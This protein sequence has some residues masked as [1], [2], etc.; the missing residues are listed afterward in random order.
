MEQGTSFT[1]DELLHISADTENRLEVFIKSKRLNMR[2]LA[3]LARTIIKE[4]GRESNMLQDLIM[5]QALR[6]LRS[7]EQAGK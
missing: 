5:M 3:S 2:E 6:D 4:I 1:E 7:Q